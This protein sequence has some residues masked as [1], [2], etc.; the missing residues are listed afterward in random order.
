MHWCQSRRS[1]RC[2]SITSYGQTSD[3]EPLSC[4]STLPVELLSDSAPGL[5]VAESRAIRGGLS[6]AVV[7]AR[8]IGVEPRLID[9]WVRACCHSTLTNKAV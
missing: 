3:T 9:A 8:F 6:E 4:S 1:C 2:L 7:A 5:L